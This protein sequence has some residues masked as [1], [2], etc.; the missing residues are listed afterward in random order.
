MATDCN[1]NPRAAMQPAL[2]IIEPTL[3]GNAGHCHDLVR[4][5]AQAAPECD[6]TVWAGRGAGAIWQG[7]GRLEPHFRRRWRRL[8]ALWLQRKLLRGPG[9]VLVAT[10]GSS[11]LISADWAAAGTI[12]P[13][14]LFMFVH[15]LGRKAGKAKW[16]TALAKRQPN[17]E[18]LS[19]T[20]ALTSFFASCGFR[21]TLVPYPIDGCLHRAKPAAGFRHLVVAGAARLDKGFDH[22]VDLVLEMQRRGTTIPIVV[23]AS[24]EERHR[25]DQAL[26]QQITRLRAANYPALTILDSTLTREQY[27][28][29]FEGGIALQ[30]YRAADFEDRVSGVTLDALAAGCPLVVTEGTW[31]AK[32]ARRFDAGVVT[33]DLSGVGLLRAAERVLADRARYAASALAASRPLAEEHSARRLLDIVLQRSPATS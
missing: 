22:V 1:D 28:D 21:S 30:P 19:P 24:L 9:R 11:D 33:S 12:P 14:K 26:A 15:W 2:H 8:Q 16:L 32:L 6:I 31:M 23:Q 18:I 10:A 17:I 7:P 25:D 5:L 4:S 20:Q 13:H 29:L 3:T 27:L